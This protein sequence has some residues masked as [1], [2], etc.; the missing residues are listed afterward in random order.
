MGIKTP[1]E[2]D[3]ALIRSFS[4]SFPL[5]LA[6]D[7]T[8]ASN[9]HA[10]RTP[11]TA[12]PLGRM[13]EKEGSRNL[14]ATK[15]LTEDWRKIES[16]KGWSIE[17]KTSE[18]RQL[19]IKVNL[20]VKLEIREAADLCNALK[21]LGIDANAWN[22]A[23]NRVRE[24]A[25]RF[26]IP[27]GKFESAASDAERRLL[28]IVRLI[29]I[30]KNTNSLWAHEFDDSEMKRLTLLIDWLLANP[31]SGLFIREIP[32]EGVDTKWFEKHQAL[33]CGV[34]Q[35][36]EE[37]RGTDRGKENADF[38][39]SLGLKR[40]PQFLRV[41]HASSWT[42]GEPDDV[43]QLTL[44]R[45]A[46]TPPNSNTVVIIE[47]EQTGLSIDI[48]PEIPILIAMGYGV[49]ALDSVDWLRGA[50]ILYFGDLDTHG[51]AILSDL[52]G[53]YPQTQSV[54]MDQETFLQYRHLAVKELSQVK[55]RPEALNAN[56]SELFDLLLSTNGR[57]EQER[58]PIDIINNAL[59]FKLIN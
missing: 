32:V 19:R 27:F 2:M 28:P 39:S 37:L 26:R 18:W 33:I 8:F 20:P 5:W 30:L 55:R 54:L 12:K 57:L 6:D 41:R 52:R 35:L 10:E 43:V 59:R 50:R 47:N 13:N 31:N 25:M 17:W 22:K 36:I 51:L 45:L 29:R 15:R 21:P 3:D 11:L 42:A 38:L 24:L 48:P 40:K 16:R 44:E 46:S 58:I 49:S 4:R 1:A 23:V 53:I 9:A 7:V 56:E 34:W 14:S